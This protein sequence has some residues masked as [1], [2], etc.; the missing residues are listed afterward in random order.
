[1]ARWWRRSS[2]QPWKLCWE[3]E[4]GS[5]SARH[6]AKRDMEKSS[7]NQ[8]CHWQILFR[9]RFLFEKPSGTCMKMFHCHDFFRGSCFRSWHGDTRYFT[10]K[11]L[12]WNLPE[13]FLLWPHHDDGCWERESSLKTMG[14]FPVC[15][16]FH[17][18]V[19]YVSGC[20]TTSRTTFLLGEWTEWTSRCQ[21]PLFWGHNFWSIPFHTH[22]GKTW[23]P[24]LPPLIARNDD[25]Y[26]EEQSTNGNLQVCGTS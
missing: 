20:F 6:L 10:I 13:K 25:C 12:F 22:L 9:W 24:P 11:I 19:T 16:N 2:C 7:G 21:T 15:S 14:F 8:T 18:N 1:M 26:G 23:Q 17:L 3:T 4:Q 5:R